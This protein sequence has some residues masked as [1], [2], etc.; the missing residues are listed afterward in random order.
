VRAAHFDA[1]FII[2]FFSLVWNKTYPYQANHG[3]RKWFKTRCEMSGMKPIN[4]ETLMEHST[5]INDSHYRLTEHDLL[6][7]YLKVAADLLTVSCE[8]DHLE[9]Q[10]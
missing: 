2:H 5:G 6:E 10:R 4:S 1:S 8:N 3:F 9:Q 7:D